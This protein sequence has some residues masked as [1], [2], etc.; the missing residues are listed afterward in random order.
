MREVSGASLENMPGGIDGKYYGWM[1]LDG[2][3]IS[4]V[5]SE[6]ARAWF[7]KPNLGGGRFAP[8]D[9]VAPSASLK[10]LNSGQVQLMDVAGDGNLDLVGLAQPT[11]GYYE[12]TRESEDFKRRPNLRLL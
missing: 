7:Y 5:L 9:V 2:E 11:P 4:G 1:D 3:G 8:T 6:Q 12:R 10:G